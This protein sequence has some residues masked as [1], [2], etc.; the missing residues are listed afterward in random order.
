[1]KWIF[2]SRDSSQLERFKKMMERADILCAVR[3][4]QL[5]LAMPLKPLDSELWVLNDGDY[6]KA[7]GLIKNW[8]GPESSHPPQK[9]R[10]SS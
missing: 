1:M 8:S 3:S 4:D 6:E 7:R 2:S 9:P 5:E 10:L